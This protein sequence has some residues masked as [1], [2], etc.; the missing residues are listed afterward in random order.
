MLSWSIVY[1]ALKNA[2]LLKYNEVRIL[3]FKYSKLGLTINVKNQKEIVI[4][5]LM[6]SFYDAMPY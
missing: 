4:L 5:F 1:V 6:S 2:R 3:L